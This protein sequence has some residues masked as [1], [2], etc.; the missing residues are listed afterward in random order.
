MRGQCRQ[1]RRKHFLRRKGSTQI[2]LNYGP[3][4]FIWRFTIHLLLSG[5]SDENMILRFTAF[6]SKIE[7]EIK[8]Q[9]LGEFPSQKIDFIAF[10]SSA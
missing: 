8:F 5:S 6:N 1:T 2:N 10:S 7:I 3:G 9:S 4:N